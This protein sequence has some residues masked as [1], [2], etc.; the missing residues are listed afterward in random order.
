VSQQL[1]R[2]EE[3]PF[4]QLVLDLDDDHKRQLEAD[5]KSWRSRL[6]QFG[7]D[8]ADEPNRIRSFYEVKATRI[9]PVGLVYLWPE[10]N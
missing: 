10:T 7:R 6:V 2:Y 9:E 5:L 4:E 8:L 1:A 3:K